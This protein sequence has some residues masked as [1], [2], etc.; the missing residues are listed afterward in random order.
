MRISLFHRGAKAAAMLVLAVFSFSPL[1]SDIENYRLTDAGLDRYERATEAM[2]QF[3]QAH[4]EMAQRLE[5]EDE[6]E[7]D[8]DGDPSLMAQQL[9]ARAPGLRAAVEKSGMKLEEYFTFTVVMAANAFGVAMAEQ[10]G[11]ADESALSSVQRANVQFVR[12]HMQRF[13]EFGERMKN[14]YPDVLQEDEDEYS[15]GDYS[16]EEYDDEY[17]EQ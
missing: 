10:F 6:D 12:K 11:S 7:E 8:A 3:A 13:Q 9:D 4:P 14:K 15:D 17:A 5:N 16:D 1:A 2:Y